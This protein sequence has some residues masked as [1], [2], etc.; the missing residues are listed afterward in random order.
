[1]DQTLA[2]LAGSSNRPLAEAISKELGLPL[3]QATLKRFANQEVFCEIHDNVRG[4]DVFLIQST[5]FPANDHL[6]EMFVLLDAL[7]RASVR[8]VTVVEPHYGYARQDRRAYPQTP[9]SAKLVADLKTKAGAGRIVTWDLHAGQIEGFHDIPLDN[10]EA[11]PLFAADIRERYA[12]NLPVIVS[13]DVG[14]ATRTRKLADLLGT[15]WAIVD[16]RRPAP[17][18]SEVMGVVGDVAG[19]PAILIDDM[20]DSGGTLV[21]AAAELLKRGATSVAAYCTHGVLSPGAVARIESSQL[22]ELVITDAIQP[23]AEQQAATK[24]RFLSVA[25]V[26][27]E[28][29]RRIQAGQSLI[30]IYDSVLQRSGIAAP[31]RRFPT[32]AA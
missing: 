8:S 13:P 14:G 15:T 4:K 29:I 6:M 10:L 24:I 31:A 26:T 20:V 3:L 2:L 21:N 17:G 28:A 27:A 16:K 22:K 7:K 23:T 25:P 9:I 18:V 32:P 5:S 19:R 11:A 12:G 30:G 1:M